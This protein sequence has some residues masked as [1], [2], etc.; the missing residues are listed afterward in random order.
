MNSEPS[1]LPL[2]DDSE[3][4]PPIN[5]PGDR[6]SLYRA[7]RS[8]TFEEVVGQK[9]VTQTLRNAVRY[10]KVAHAYLFTGPRGTGKTSTARILARAVNCLQAHDGEPCNRCAI[11]ISMLERRSLDLVEID[12]ASNNS[13]DDVRE[14]RERVNLHPAEGRQKVF[15]IDEVHMLSI[16]AFNALLKTLE[17]PPDHILFALATTELQ[18]VPATVRS[19]CQLLELRP[20]PP[21]DMVDRLRYV[22]RKEGIQAD[23]EVLRFITSQSTGSLRDALS[24]LEQVRAFC[25]DALQLAEVEAALGV[26]RSTQVA[27]LAGAMAAGDL[28]EAL[29]IAGDLMDGGVDPRQLTRQLSGYWRDALVARSRQKPVAEP[30]VA[31]CRADQIVPVLYSLMGVESATRRS[32]SPRWALETAIADATLRLA[33]GKDTS[34]PAAAV[35][36]Q[37][38]IAPTEQV[39]VAAPN[40]VAATAQAL[41]EDE[42]VEIFPTSLIPD[43][44]RPTPLEEEPVM[45]LV[46]QEVVTTEPSLFNQ[47]TGRVSAESPS[48]YAATTVEVPAEPAAANQTAPAPN[49]RALWP[50][51]MRRLN[52]NRKVQVYSLLQKVMLDSISTENGVVSLPVHVSDSF[53]R[54]RLESPAIKKVVEETISDVLG[55]RWGVRC[56]TIDTKATPSRPSIDDLDYLE[57]FAAEAAA[58]NGEPNRGVDL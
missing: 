9:H 50:Q 49:L 22:C 30:Q 21:V 55:G 56:V 32:D 57:Q 54:S 42:P 24:L 23:D 12:G 35:R 39:K 34:M 3:Q 43:P 16:G 25:G 41:H 29:M 1:L 19:R 18:K 52:E 8:L 5:A 36:P 31:S 45:D 10:G 38:I 40:P 28:P 15:I 13:V 17:E 46:L 11:C 53:V 44:D 37:T 26:A 2:P 20:I 51:V 6:A 4:Q 14:L 58:R 7:Y 47:E 27:S 33:G 48:E